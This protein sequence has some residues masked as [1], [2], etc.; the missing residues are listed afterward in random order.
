MAFCAMTGE[1]LLVT[2]LAFMIRCNRRWVPQEGID[3]TKM[4]GVTE[5]VVAS[6]S[7]V[8]RWGARRHHESRSA[9]RST[10]ELR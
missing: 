1:D 9:W 8:G 6:R 7:A 10:V 2:G 4:E 3:A 5:V